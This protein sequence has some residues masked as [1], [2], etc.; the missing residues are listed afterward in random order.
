MDKVEVPLVD[1]MV[2]KVE[3]VWVCPDC[4]I[5]SQDHTRYACDDCHE[6][7]HLFWCMGCGKFFERIFGWGNQV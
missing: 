7:H 5:E 6:I 2:E 3:M 1:G 4:G